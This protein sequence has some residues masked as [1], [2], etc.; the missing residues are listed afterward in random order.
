M[1]QAAYD[2]KFTHATDRWVYR[3]TDDYEGMRTT[4]DILSAISASQFGD[5]GTVAYL[6]EK[7]EPGV[8]RAAE[9]VTVLMGSGFENDH[10]RKSYWKGEIIPGREVTAVSIEALRAMGAAPDVPGDNLVTRGIDL[11]VLQAGDVLEVGAVRLRRSPATH[12]P[13]ALFKTR[14]GDAAFR[15]A[16]QGQRG[17]LFTVEQGGEMQVG[18]PIR[19]LRS[20]SNL[21][22]Q[23][24]GQ[25]A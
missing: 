25:G 3:P 17:A 22:G 13:C 18:D 15:A 5:E 12:K 4:E 1:R 7:P 24:E 6:V 11:S 19:V 21:E 23:L 14:L 16:A 10:P 20:Q 8:H 2:T 9:R